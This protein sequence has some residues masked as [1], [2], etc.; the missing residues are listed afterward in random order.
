MNWRDQ[1]R[2]RFYRMLM[3]GLCEFAGQ[4]RSKSLPKAAQ[5][6]CNWTDEFQV[7]YLHSAWARRV[8]SRGPAREHNDL[9]GTLFNLSQRSSFSSSGDGVVPLASR[10]AL[11][12]GS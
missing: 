1:N 2:V 4:F 11:G 8:L 7:A 5:T 10:G 6:V 3:V 12:A 9:F